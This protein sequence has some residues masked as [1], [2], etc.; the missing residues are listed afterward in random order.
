MIRLCDKLRPTVRIPFHAG[1]LCLALLSVFSTVSASSA[2][3]PEASRTRIPVTVP[4]NY[5][6]ADIT[7]VGTGLVRAP[8]KSGSKTLSRKM[9]QWTGWIRASASG[10][11]ELSLPYQGARIFINQQQIFTHSQIKSE[12]TIT[13][14]ELL[15]N[16]Y[17]AIAVEVPESKDS[18]LPLQ[19][20]RPDGRNQTVPKAYLYAPLATASDRQAV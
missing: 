10:K 20:R 8:V 2:P 1:I 13:Q 12:P 14:I 5:C 15:A 7:S 9:V 16:R 11:Y 19:W 6:S 3:T 4:R 18:N 17:Y